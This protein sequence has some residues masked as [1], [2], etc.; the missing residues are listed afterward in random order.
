[1]VY[2]YYVG[3]PIDAVGAVGAFVPHVGVVVVDACYMWL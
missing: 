3:V 2:L 1:M